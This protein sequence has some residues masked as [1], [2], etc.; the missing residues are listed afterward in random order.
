MSSRWDVYK[1]NSFK[2]YC[3]T[4]R[5]NIIRTAKTMYTYTKPI[6]DILIQSFIKIVENTKN[7]TRQSNRV[8]RRPDEAC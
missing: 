8:E 5:I 1:A 6:V 3:R 4:I 7:K 2:E